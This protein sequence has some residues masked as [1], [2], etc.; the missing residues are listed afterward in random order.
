MRTVKSNAKRQN[1]GLTVPVATRQARKIVDAVM[2]GVMATVESRLSHDLTTDTPTVVTTVTF[3]ANID[4][5]ARVALGVALRVQLP[6]HFTDMREADSSF[7][8][9]RKV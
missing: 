6:N 9:T 1:V 5:S 7:V 3:P 4:Q 8:I 2:P